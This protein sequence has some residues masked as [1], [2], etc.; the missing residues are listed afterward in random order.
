MMTT[1][2]F[3]AE[4][5]DPDTYTETFEKYLNIEDIPTEKRSDIYVPMKDYL[6]ALN[7]IKEL[8]AICHTIQKET[9]KTERYTRAN[10]MEE[11][12]KYYKGY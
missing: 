1:N 12:E 10:D 7:T 9:K 5:F 4:F 2:R 11:I 8:Q 3:V 6:S